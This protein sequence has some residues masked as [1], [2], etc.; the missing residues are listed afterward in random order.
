MNRPTHHGPWCDEPERF[1]ACDACQP[2]E[3][4][5]MEAYLTISQVVF[6][7]IAAACAAVGVY[8]WLNR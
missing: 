2:N 8:R 4:K 3:R 7:S 6:L 1:G 5:P